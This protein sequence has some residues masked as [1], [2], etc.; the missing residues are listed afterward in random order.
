MEEFQ[1]NPEFIGLKIDFVNAFN[2][3]SRSIFL[4]ECF[5]KFPHIFKWVHFCYSNHSHLFFGNYIISSQAGVQQGDP[6]GPFLFCLVLQ[7]L[8]SKIKDE[9]PDLDLNNWYM[10]D[11][12]LF[13]KTRDVLKAWNIIKDFGPSLGLQVNLSKCELI[14]SSNNGGVFA[15]FEPELVKI[16]D[17]NMTILGSPI[18]SSQHCEN[19]ISSKLNKKLEILLNKIE[20][21]DHSQSSF[22]LLLFCA[23]FCKMVWYIRTIPPDLISDSCSRFDVA[24]LCSFEKLIGA[25]L[26]KLSLQQARLSTKF[27]GIGLRASKTHSA[28]AYI[29]SF[30]MSKPLIESF[31]S[32][33]VSNSH[34]N[35]AISMFNSLVGLDHCLDGS[36]SSS[37]PSNQ[38]DLSH[39]IDSESFRT[40][41]ADSTNLNKARL[42]ACSMPHATAWVRALPAHQ[43]K[44]SCL[45]WSICMKR[46]L[47]IPIFNQDHLCSACQL[48]VM[49]IFGHH[50]SVC[51]VSGDR[52]RRH[53]ILRDILYD[54]CSLAAWGPTKEVPHIFPSSSERP[55]DIFV[56][57]FS[58]GK[59]LVL[60]VAVTCPLQHKHLLETAQTA[61]F[62]CN[63]YAE[64]IKI[65]N[66]QERVE[67]EGFIYLPAVFE[68]FG[69]FSRDLPDFLF[70]LTKGL[71]L[72]LNEL[73]SITSK[74][75]YEN[76][77][78]A[79][80]KSTAR[81]ISSRFPDF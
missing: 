42:L 7:V 20:N 65:K 51:P 9:V 58:L 66:Y 70:K 57:N 17:G 12:S 24:V 73:K 25:G 56:P 38:H 23:S 22:L 2:A 21:L 39:H 64:Q 27:G 54:F 46:W 68:S 14:S 40:L 79:L 1:N 76:L 72:R 18:G 5:D 47:G 19:W 3:V 52:I 16:A 28:A 43:N 63:E 49:D 36:D 71:S 33:Q 80:M 69:G 13:G 74:Y 8:I 53:N 77:S 34:I 29:A 48:H 10:D 62:A 50:A 30:F 78:C 26:S 4:N 41:L 67:R 45:E 55:A 37:C 60:D 44:F 6:L 15:D 61:G 75:L 31:L 35:S 59:D 32:K 11:G 81:S